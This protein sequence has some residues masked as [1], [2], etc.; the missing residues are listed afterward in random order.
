MEITLNFSRVGL[1]SNKQCGV[2][3]ANLLIGTVVIEDVV[4][5]AVS[6]YC[7]QVVRS[8]NE[9]EGF[10]EQMD[11]VVTCEKV[12]VGVDLNGYVGSDVGDVGEVHGGFGIG[13]I[14]DGGIRLLDWAVGKGLL[15]INTYFQKRESW[16]IIFRS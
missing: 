6:C 3:V 13:Q 9:K 10:Y 8:V 2:I 15:L 12:L 1:R 5:E 11:K 7:P 16:H 4:W 14:I